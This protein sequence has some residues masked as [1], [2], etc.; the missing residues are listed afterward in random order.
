LGQ[1]ESGVNPVRANEAPVEP[2]P[3]RRRDGGRLLQAYELSFWDALA[4]RL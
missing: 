2:V 4:E 3:V 1:P